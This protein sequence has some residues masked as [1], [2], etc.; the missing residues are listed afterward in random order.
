LSKAFNHIGNLS[1]DEKYES[2]YW[3]RFVQGIVAGV[4]LSVIISQAFFAQ[5]SAQPPEGG[6]RGFKITVPLLAFVGGFSSDLVYRILERIIAGI[7]TLIRGGVNDR[8]DAQDQQM[9]SEFRMKELSNRQAQITKL[10]A[11]KGELPETA[12]AARARVDELLTSLAGEDVD[13]SIAPLDSPDNELQTQVAAAIDALQI[14]DIKLAV[15]GGIVVLQGT[16]PDQ[17]TKDS[18]I[19][20]VTGISGVRAVNADAV[21][22]K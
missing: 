7:D 2:S 6:L 20:A 13:H 21:E 8:V 17:A 12:T 4:V 19:V 5:S 3:I 10:V 11:L 18:L 22:I 9:R 1:Y 15:L 14:R 16:V